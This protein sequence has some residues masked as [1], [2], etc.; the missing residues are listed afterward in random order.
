[1]PDE[2]YVV[3]LENDCCED[4]TRT[5]RCCRL[6]NKMKGMK[7]TRELYLIRRSQTGARKSLAGPTPE[8]DNEANPEQHRYN[9]NLKC[10]SSSSHRSG[11]SVEQ[12]LCIPKIIFFNRLRSCICS[13]SPMYRRVGH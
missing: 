8:K 2:M 10:G 12:L 3:C 11:V 4:F 7:H 13:C 5:L 9:I 1:M 6:L